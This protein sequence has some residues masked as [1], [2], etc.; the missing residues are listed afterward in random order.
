MP[1]HREGQWLTAT[2]TEH[3]AYEL[4]PG[5]YRLSL[6]ADR[7]VT[8]AQAIAGL[9]VA[10]IADEWG[11]LLWEDTP[12]TAMVWRLIADAARPLGLDPLDAVI[13]VQQ[14]EFPTTAAE[15]AEWLR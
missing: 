10:E 3:V 1:I 9:R 11:P 13:R 2:R 14:R 8:G 5:V 15:W 4:K 7:E 6:A 12:N